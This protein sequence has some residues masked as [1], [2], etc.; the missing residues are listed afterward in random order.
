M[1][2][3]TI[4]A[5]L[6]AVR[7]PSP[8]VRRRSDLL[9]VAAGPSVCRRHGTPCPTAHLGMSRD[10]GGLAAAARFSVARRTLALAGALASMLSGSVAHADADSDADGSESR[11]HVEW[12]APAGCPDAQHVTTRMRELVGGSAHHAPPPRPL[13]LRGTVTT[14]G[15][16]WVLHTVTGP[17][18][19]PEQ[20]TIGA[21]NCELLAEAFALIAAFVVAPDLHPAEP[22]STAPKTPQPP[23][24]T[25]ES[26]EGP[27]PSSATP[28][29]AGIRLGVGPMVAVGV[30][31][32]P[33]LATGLGGA[34]ALETSDAYRG[35]LAGMLWLGQRTVFANDP[36]PLAI[37]VDLASV[38]PSVCVPFSRPQ[39]IRLSACGHVDVG[40]MTGE[41]EA[42]VPGKGRSWWLSFGGGFAA[43]FRVTDALSLRG[44]L[45]LTIP[46]FRPRFALDDDSAGTGHSVRPSALVAMLSFEPELQFSPMVRS[47]AGHRR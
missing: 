9:G 41:G 32:L 37:S 18:S 42:L 43:A 8:T 45:D 26:T 11:W 23:A 44:R 46:V 20:R 7:R 29:P 22:E 36:R 39:G 3:G 13:V 5:L 12:S 38:G 17:T 19:T 31:H 25:D 6:G 33:S 34:I 35:E 15:A 30:G 21:P 10:W 16:D 28:R 24:T 4:R 27:P 47:G 1:V 40:V 2:H 14:R